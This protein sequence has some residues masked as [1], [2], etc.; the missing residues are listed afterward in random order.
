MT[1]SEELKRARDGGKHAMSTMIPIALLNQ[2][3][4]EMER[5]RGRLRKAAE[6]L[7]LLEG[8]IWLGGG[9]TA[10]HCRLCGGLRWE[11]HHDDC[12]YTALL[13]EIND[14]NKEG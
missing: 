8:G 6:L 4:A 7:E 1:L 10:E 12:S 9:M 11:S 2:C 5:Q 3:I 13:V 14:A